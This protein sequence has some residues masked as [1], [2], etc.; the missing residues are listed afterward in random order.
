LTGLFY[1]TGNEV[2]VRHG[3]TKNTL[4]GLSGQTATMA[5]NAH[6]FCV[7]LPGVVGGWLSSIAV[8]SSPVGIVTSWP[9]QASEKI[10]LLS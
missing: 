10:E 9:T 5:V 1:R 6:G 2:E 7:R 8:Q 3:R 4:C